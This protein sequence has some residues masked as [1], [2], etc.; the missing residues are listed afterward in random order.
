MEGLNSIDYLISEEI[1]DKDN[2]DLDK[3]E[4]LTN[5]EKSNFKNCYNINTEKLINNAK[6][7][8]GNSETGD[9]YCLKNG[10]LYYIKKSGKIV[11]IGSVFEDISRSTNKDIFTY[12]D[13]EK[14]ILTGIDKQFI[15]ETNIDNIVQFHV[16]LDS[17]KIT[18]I[19]IPDTVKIIKK[20]AFADYT[21]LKYIRLNESIE[22]IEDF[23]FQNCKSLKTIII[24]TTLNSIG[25]F[26]FI[27]CEN[28]EFLEIKNGIVSIGE[29]A[30]QNCSLLKK[31]NIP[32][33]VQ[34][35]GKSAFAHC[36]LLEN[37][38]VD[39]E[40]KNYCGKD[41]VLFNKEM[42]ILFQYPLNKKTEEYEIPNTVVSIDSFAFTY[43][44]NLKTLSIPTSVVSIG[45][46]TLYGIEK[47]KF[48]EAKNDLLQIPENKWGADNIE[49]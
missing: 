24:P 4:T 49:F 11:D 48:L 27:N 26:S 23:A 12:E 10:E 18:D 47:I 8:K 1:M 25:S 39:Q 15:N 9:I 35:I 40:N 36:Q 29:S 21:S 30:F 19:S 44:K 22:K 16:Y 38:C 13:D 37:I 33:T 46:N 45:S 31:I 5:L 17:E 28:L 7:G 14:T 20:S 6:Y 43:C 32:N 41:G 42:S 34:N 3:L 2:I